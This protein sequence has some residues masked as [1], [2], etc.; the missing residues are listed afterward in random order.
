M[1]ISGVFARISAD[2]ISCADATGIR[3][4]LKSKRRYFIRKWLKEKS[5]PKFHLLGFCVWRK[6]MRTGLYLRI[7]DDVGYLFAEK[8][9]M[10]RANGNLESIGGAKICLHGFSDI[11]SVAWGK[12]EWLVN[13]F[14]WEIGCV[15]CVQN[16]DDFRFFCW[17]WGFFWKRFWFRSSTIFIKGTCRERIFVPV[18]LIL[19][20]WQERGKIHKR[21]IYL[22][23]R[24]SWLFEIVCEKIPEFFRGYFVFASKI[25]SGKYLSDVRVDRQNRFVIRKCLYC[26]S[27]IWSYARKSDECCGVVWK[28][29]VVFLAY[30]TRSSKHVFCSVIIAESFVVRKKGFK[31]GF[32]EWVDRRKSWQD[33]G[34]V[35][36]RSRNLR[37]LK[38]SLWEPD[39]IG[40]ILYRQ[41]KILSPRE[42]VAT[43][44]PIPIQEDFPG[45]RNESVRF[46]HF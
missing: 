18:D 8:P 39:P 34:E 13:W 31:I 15:I 32:S 33:R 21:R 46:L 14:L 25:V 44:F 7:A 3:K 19:I 28:Y 24:K 27:G 38:H 40:Q 9:I 2:R 35:L 42:C 41:M 16:D 17:K 45:K 11:R 26:G 10:N 22:T 20:F 6:R 4:Q 30:D 29:S 37:L 5:F 36:D 1:A 23:A 43:V 12:H